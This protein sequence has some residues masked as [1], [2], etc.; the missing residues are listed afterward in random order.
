MEQS[1]LLIINISTCT[2]QL[3]GLHCFSFSALN[4]L[5]TFGGSY[6]LLNKKDKRGKRVELHTKTIFGPLQCSLLGF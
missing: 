6:S 3:K 5:N 4:N 2:S 1:K